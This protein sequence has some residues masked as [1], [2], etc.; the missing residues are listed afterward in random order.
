ALYLTGIGLPPVPEEVMIVSSAAAATA[1]GLNWWWAWPAVIVGIVCA[2]ATLYG[3]GR[4]WGPKLF[5]HRWVQR[6]MSTERRRRIEKRF[7]NH[8]IK[9]LLTARLLPPLRTGVFLIAGAVRYP[10]SRFLLADLCYAVVGVGIFFFG[11][12]ALIALLEEVGHVA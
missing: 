3:A 7:T 9:I 1:K 12:Q 4:L 8:G 11:S 5:E 10:L 2:D 6:L